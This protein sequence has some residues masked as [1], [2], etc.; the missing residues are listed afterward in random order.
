VF[1][2]GARR[3]GQDGNLSLYSR[4]F[5]EQGG[6]RKREPNPTLDRTVSISWSRDG[7]AGGEPNPTLGG[8]V[9]VSWSRD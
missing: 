8:T 5:V 7:S 3:E 6:K 1:F 4:C 2:T 9:S